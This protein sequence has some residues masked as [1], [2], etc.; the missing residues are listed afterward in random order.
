MSDTDKMMA[1]GSWLSTK[2]LQLTAE[3]YSL[4]VNT[5]APIDAVRLKAGHIEATQ[6]ILEAFTKLYRGD[7]NKFEV[8]YLGKDPEKEDKES[9]DVP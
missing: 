7:L 3:L 1:F 4:S 5:K 9:T 8:D 2:R 6:Q